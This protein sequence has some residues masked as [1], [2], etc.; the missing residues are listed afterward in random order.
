MIMHDG[1]KHVPRQPRSRITE[2]I[3]ILFPPD[4][5]HQ[6]S[7][8]IYATY[9]LPKLA[10]IINRHELGNVQA[11]SIHTV[12]RVAVTVGIEPATYYRRDV[13]LDRRTR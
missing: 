4:L 8:R 1:I 12:A 3:G 9:Q 10:P 11:K 13:G 2:P 6:K 7:L 5:A